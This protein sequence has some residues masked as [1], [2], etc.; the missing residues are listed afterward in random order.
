MMKRCFFLLAV[1]LLL[2]S[3]QKTP[4]DS[5]MLSAE[6]MEMPDI[7]LKN[8][9]YTLSTGEGEPIVINASLMK[10]FISGEKVLLEDFT[11][12]Q[13]DAEGN[14]FIKGHAGQ[15][16]IDTST[17]E[18]RFTGGAFIE[19]LRD[20]LS[21]SA[22]SIVFSS[23]NSTVE[24]EGYAEVTFDGGRITGKDVFADL[25]AS[26]LEIGELYSGEMVT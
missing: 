6:D 16:S 18:C 10:V 5:D 25:T 3:C 7:M 13:N 19:Q 26:T 14:P 11:F 9:V 1:V 12:T 20:S 8:S 17:R 4:T 22:S 21:V 23:R 15:G 24:A 2:F